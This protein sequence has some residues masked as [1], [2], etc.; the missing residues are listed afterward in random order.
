MHRVSQYVHESL[1]IDAML[2]P[3]CKNIAA[4]TQS[5]TQSSLIS[6][7][8]MATFT[9][10]SLADVHV[11]AKGAKTCQLT[12]D[13]AKVQQSA[14]EFCTT[15]FG[16]SNFDKDPLATRQNLE[17]RIPQQ[18][19]AWFTEVDEFMV[20]YLVA[21]S[22]RIFKKQL[23]LEQVRESF[24]LTLKRQGDY[25]ALLRTKINS[26][27]RQACRYWTA[28]QQKREPPE[29]WRSAEMR[30]MLHLSHLWIM[31]RSCGLVVNATDLLIQESVGAFP[32][33]V[34]EPS[35]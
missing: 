31:G 10:W 2:I 7:A 1:L 20:G 26:T 21:H 22:E 32:F 19:E 34:Q 5:E 23:T 14:D 4:F 29:D 9:N 11:N 6:K 17:L 30:P 33:A 35:Q 27:G 12:S 13:G 15:P 8:S 16:P 24:H 28:D 25:P 18:L 3:G